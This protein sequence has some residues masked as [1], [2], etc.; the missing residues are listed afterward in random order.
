LPF[1]FRHVAAMPDVHFGMGAIV[2]SVIAT[3][4]AIVFA[5]V[6]VDIGCGMEAVRTGLRATDL[7]DSGGD[8]FDRAGGAARPLNDG[9]PGDRGFGA[10][11]RAACRRPGGAGRG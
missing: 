3:K 4:G 1:V 7:P 2:G 10:I 6:G 11:R 5:A 9:G 8:P